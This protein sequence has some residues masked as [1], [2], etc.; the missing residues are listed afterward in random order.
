MPDFKPRSDREKKLA[1]DLA[2]LFSGF[3]GHLMEL[4]GDDPDLSDI[5]QEAFDNLTKEELAVFVPALLATA[6]DAAGEM[7]V[8]IP[9][10]VDWGLVNANALEWARQYGYELV[11]DIDQT[12]RRVVQNA[13]SSFYQDGLTLGDLRESLIRGGFS[14][15]RA[16]M[17]AVTETTRA[18]VQGQ[19]ITVNELEKNGIVMIPIWQTNEDDRV[20]VICKPRNNK[21]RGSNWI[22]DPPAHPRC[23]CNLRYEFSTPEL[24][25]EIANG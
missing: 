16:D 9:I 12:S 4:F 19:K 3:V 13:V 15:V 22:D 24:L 21:P 11:R 1:R 25:E 14:P 17:I 18:S 6:I 5:P 20:C 2:R 23:N 8:D 10:G 7:L